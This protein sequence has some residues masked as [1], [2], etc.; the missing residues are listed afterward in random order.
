M[1]RLST[2][3]KLKLISINSSFCMACHQ[4]LSYMY[5]GS[6]TC[7]LFPPLHGSQL[8]IAKSTHPFYCFLTFNCLAR[9]SLI[10]MPKHKR[11]NS[12]DHSRWSTVDLLEFIWPAFLTM[13]FFMFLSDGLLNTPLVIIILNGQSPLMVCFSFYNLFIFLILTHS[14]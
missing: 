14:F 3:F 5:K 12:P 4:S 2:H 13:L 1:N 9:Q 7:L 8:F 10:L 6:I 11:S